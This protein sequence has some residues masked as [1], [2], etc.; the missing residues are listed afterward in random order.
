MRFDLYYKPKQRKTR[1]SEINFPYPNLSF[2]AIKQKVNGIFMHIRNT[3]KI[4]TIKTWK[5][6]SLSPDREYTNQ[7][8]DQQ[9]KQE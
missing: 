4:Q 1:D 6:S 5:W 2:T 3:T 8:D 7:F 9:A